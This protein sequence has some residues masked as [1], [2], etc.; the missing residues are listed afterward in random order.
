MVITLIVCKYLFYVKKH[1]FTL[2]NIVSIYLLQ[3][4]TVLLWAIARFS[5]DGPSFLKH[6]LGVS[7]VTSVGENHAGVPYINAFRCLGIC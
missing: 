4:P 7:S 3:W 1:S 6:M 2:N 5:F